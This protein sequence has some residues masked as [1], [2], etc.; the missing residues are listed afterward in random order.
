MQYGLPVRTR[1]G[2]AIASRRRRSAERIALWLYCPVD[3]VVMKW[4]R[5]LDEDP[6]VYQIAGIVNGRQSDGGVTQNVSGFR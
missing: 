5:E 3:S 2:A 6:E 4:L 1:F